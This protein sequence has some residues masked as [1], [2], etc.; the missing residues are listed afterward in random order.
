MYA[1]LPPRTVIQRSPVFRSAPARSKNYLPF[2]VYAHVHSYAKIPNLDNVITTNDSGHKT[3]PPTARI[4]ATALVC[5]SLRLAG[6][7]FKKNTP[8][9]A[10]TIIPAGRGR[11]HQDTAEGR[12]WRCNK[13]T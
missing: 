5:L 3:M 11:T 13:R 12:V 1:R 4:Q 8:G 7:V 9:S 2:G 6:T 10:N